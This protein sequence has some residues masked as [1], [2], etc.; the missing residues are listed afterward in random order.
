MF[1]LYTGINSKFFPVSS[2]SVSPSDVLFIL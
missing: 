2:Q 1:P